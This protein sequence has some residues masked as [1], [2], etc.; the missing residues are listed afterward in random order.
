[1]DAQ[2]AVVSHSWRCSKPGWMG[3]WAAELMRDSP[4]HGKGMDVDHH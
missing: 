3:P 4:A 2:R 1:M